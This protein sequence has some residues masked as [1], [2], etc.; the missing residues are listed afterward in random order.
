MAPRRSTS[1][2]LCRA[3]MRAGSDPQIHAHADAK[4]ETT[5]ITRQLTATSR[6]AT[7]PNCSRARRPTAGVIHH[8]SRTPPR[9]PM[10]TSAAA[11]SS[12]CLAI[13]EWRAPRARPDRQLAPAIDRSH[14]QESREIRKG[15]QHRE[16]G[17]SREKADRSRR[18]ACYRRGDGR[19]HDACRRRRSAADVIQRGCLRVPGRREARDERRRCTRYPART[20]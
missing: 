15:D 3:A 13:S 20:A 18:V 6:L 9:M 14:D 2:T 8:A 17:G 5:P 12:S 7:P 4:S 16:R 19:R 1:T 11:S 10:A